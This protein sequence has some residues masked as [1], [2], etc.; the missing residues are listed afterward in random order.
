MIPDGFNTFWM[1]SGTSKTFTKHGPFC[2]FFFYAEMIQKIQEIWKRPSHILT[3]IS[4][5]FGNPKSPDMLT[6]PTSENE[7]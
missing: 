6:L 1:I 5:H 4:H 3:F 7:N 2:H